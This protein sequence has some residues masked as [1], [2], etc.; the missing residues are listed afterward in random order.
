M[1]TTTIL[2]CALLV[3]LPMRI[4]AEPEQDV[5]QQFVFQCGVALLIVAVVGTSVYVIHKCNEHSEDKCLN[6][7]E[8]VPEDEAVCPNCGHA[9]RCDVCNTEFCEGE[10]RCSKCD[11]PVPAPVPPANTVQMSVNGTDWHTIIP[12]GQQK[13]SG[14]QIKSFSSHAEFDL[15]LAEQENVNNVNTFITPSDRSG[16]FRLVNQ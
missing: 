12:A 14:L 10:T 2:I 1:K 13:F 4:N 9:F 15:W 7:D 8:P 16:F 6:C 11:T 5:H 3:A